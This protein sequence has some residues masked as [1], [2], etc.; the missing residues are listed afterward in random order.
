MCLRSGILSLAVES[1]RFQ[2][3]PEEDG[4]C[5]LCDLDE[6]RG[7]VCSIGQRDVDYSMFPYDTSDAVQFVLPV[8]HRRMRVLCVQLVR[9]VSDIMRFRR[10]YSTR[11]GLP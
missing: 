4:T 7:D 5:L 8:C 10:V 6:V 3:V 11:Y 1:G 9:L 2:S